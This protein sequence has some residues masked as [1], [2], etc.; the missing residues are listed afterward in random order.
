MPELKDPP[1][2]AQSASPV[3]D[4]THSLS[5]AKAR[6][7]HAQAEL[8]RHLATT[9]PEDPFAAERHAKVERKLRDDVALAECDV[10]MLSRMLTE[11][12]Q[13]VYSGE[14]DWL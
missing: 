13:D 5:Q 1:T 14:N 7:R 10:A 4:I 9:A 11:A 6:L 12:A 3:D 2:A 8:G